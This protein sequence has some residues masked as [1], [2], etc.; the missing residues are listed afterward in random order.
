MQNRNYFFQLPHELVLQ[1]ISYTDI[2]DH[3][4]LA[5]TCSYLKKL[6][7][8]NSLWKD[9]LL[10]E[11]RLS[12]SQ[13]SKLFFQNNSDARLPQ[14]RNSLEIFVRTLTSI[15]ESKKFREE[16]REIVQIGIDYLNSETK[17]ISINAIFF[18]TLIYAMIYQDQ[19]LKK[20]KYYPEMSFGDM[21]THHDIDYNID[22]TGQINPAYERFVIDK[23]GNLVLS[24]KVAIT[25]DHIKNIC[26][27]L[28]PTHADFI[29]LDHLLKTKPY[30][31]YSND[32]NMAAKR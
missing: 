29:Y 21:F 13:N 28:I 25:I 30:F 22:L 1:V 11:F 26:D 32:F 3:G 7:N 4:S 14:F 31:K 2:A 17:T 20:L 9:K 8:D 12:S 16:V 10:P 5:Q 27:H 24:K 15:M 6:T 19:L 18:G 23:I